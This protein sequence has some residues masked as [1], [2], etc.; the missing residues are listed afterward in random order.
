MFREAVVMSVDPAD[1]H[2]LWSQIDLLQSPEKIK[3]DQCESK[4]IKINQNE[5]K[6]NHN[7]SK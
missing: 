4:C 2:P 3:M 7:I 5:S 1:R 6:I